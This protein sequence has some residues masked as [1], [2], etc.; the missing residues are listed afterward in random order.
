MC[1]DGNKYR[2]YVDLGDD[3]DDDSSP[4]AKDALVFMVVNV[5]GSWKVPCA[6][7][8]VDVLS[9]AE[10]ANLIKVCIEH[11]SDVGVKV[12]SLTCDG[13]SC[14]FKMLSELG[15]RPLDPTHLNSSF[16]HPLN[17]SEHVHVFLMS[18]IC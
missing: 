11:L 18:A 16:P 9:G 7:F 14:H 4:M 8:F 13:P 1:W 2:G 6:Y 12:A 15:A 5:N 3:I 10:R 17:G